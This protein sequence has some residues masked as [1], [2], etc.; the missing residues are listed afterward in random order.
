MFFA[1]LV[2]S[3]S[4]TSFSDSLSQSKT[5]FESLVETQQAG[6]NATHHSHPTVMSLQGKIEGLSTGD[7]G[8]KVSDENSCTQGV[9]FDYNY[10][11]AIQDS[12]FN[13]LLGSQ[14]DLNLNY[15]QDYYLCL[16]VNGELVDGPQQFRGGQGQ[17]GIEDVN[18]SGFAT[19]FVPYD[20]AISNVD[21]GD[22]NFIARGVT[23][24]DADCNATM[25]YD[26][27]TRDMVIHVE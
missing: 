9:F 1:A 4:A 3:F 2:F 14:Q 26:S 12:L 10:S 17:I 27:E 5:G 21:I 23:C 24:L 19:Q 22:N 20:G 6:S 16:Y 8:I 15:N 18:A 25:Y 7:L 13:L 11:N